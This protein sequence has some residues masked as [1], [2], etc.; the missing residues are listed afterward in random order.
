MKG[1]PAAALAGL[2]LA[3]AAGTAAAQGDPAAE[4]KAKQQEALKARLDAK[5][6]EPWLT[7]YG[8]VAD[9]DKARER[10]KAEKKLIVGY[11]TRSY[12]K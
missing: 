10:A 8:W 7:D 1:I 11:F 4:K 2:V 9:Y 6:K 3:L 5:L 12:A